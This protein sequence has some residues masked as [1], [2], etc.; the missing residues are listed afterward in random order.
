MG[1]DKLWSKSQAR[2]DDGWECS[3]LFHC[4]IFGWTP[5]PM[6]E[7][8]WSRFT[9]AQDLNTRKLVVPALSDLPDELLNG[10]GEAVVEDIVLVRPEPRATIVVCSHNL[11]SEQSH[12]SQATADRVCT[13]T[14]NRRR[15]GRPRSNCGRRGSRGTGCSCTC[16]HEQSVKMYPKRSQAAADWLCSCTPPPSES[17]CMTVVIELFSIWM[18]RV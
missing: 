6:P 9:R 4:A 8:T 13:Y 16:N 18:L 14:G 17:S 3:D 15:A 11:S 12:E 10:Y 2:F 5:P 7:E 1:Y